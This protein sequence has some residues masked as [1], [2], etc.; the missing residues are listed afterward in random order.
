MLR[1]TMIALFA[2]ASVSMKERI[3]Q[4]GQDRSIALGLPLDI[5]GR[6]FAPDFIG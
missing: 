5:M 2:A 3:V 6:E 1:N 4:R